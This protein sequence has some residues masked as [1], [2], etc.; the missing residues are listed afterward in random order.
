MKYGSILAFF[1]LLCVSGVLKAAK[2]ETNGIK[3]VQIKGYVGQR[4]D[5][6][7]QERVKKQDVDEIV[8][9]FAKQDEVRERWGTEFW[10]KWVQGAIGS[11]DYTKDDDLYRLIQYSARKLLSYQLPDGYLGNYDKDHQLKG[12][13]VWGNMI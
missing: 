8:D 6:C 3:S 2:N 13:D 9:V 4:I 12:W 11:Y 10:G 7:I 1:M 5:Q